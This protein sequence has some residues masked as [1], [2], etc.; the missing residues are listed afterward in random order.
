M[1]INQKYCENCLDASSKPHGI[2]ICMVFYII[3]SNYQSNGN[4]LNKRLISYL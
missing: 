2:I 4:K 3:L 1:C